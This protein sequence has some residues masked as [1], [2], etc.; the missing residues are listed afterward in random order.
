M[1]VRTRAG[2]SDTIEE[3]VAVSPHFPVHALP[4]FLDWLRKQAKEFLSGSYHNMARHES[5]GR[6][7]PSTALSVAV[8][9]FED[10][11]IN[12]TPN[13]SPEARRPLAGG[14]RGPRGVGKP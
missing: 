13:A 2:P 5:Q 1:R 9:A 14:R 12:G 4:A 7:R 11:M 8:F 10:P 3:R 6:S